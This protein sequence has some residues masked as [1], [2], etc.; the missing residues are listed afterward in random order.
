MLLSVADGLTVVF[1]VGVVVDAAGGIF[2][3]GVV[4]DVAFLLLLLAVAVG[5]SVFTRYFVVFVLMPCFVFVLFGAVV[6]VV[7]FD[8]PV[9]VVCRDA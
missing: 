8:L 5:G 6:A 3:V 4:L 7:D 1:R 2:C 9:G